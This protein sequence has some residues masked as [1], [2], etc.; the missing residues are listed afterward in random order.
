MQADCIGDGGSEGG[1]LDLS[2]T[3]W[4]G[5]RYIVNRHAG[6]IVEN[7]MA[8]HLGSHCHEAREKHQIS[9]PPYA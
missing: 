2:R 4:L 8:L 1:D 9:A 6:R 5:V 3:G 7:C